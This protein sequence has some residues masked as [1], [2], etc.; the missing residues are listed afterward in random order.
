[1]APRSLY[2]CDG[3]V[4]DQYYQKG[5]SLPVFVGSGASQRGLGLGSVLGGLFRMAV[6]LLKQGGKALLKEGA[7]TGLQVAQDVMSGQTLKTAAQQRAKQAGKRLFEQAIG[8]TE[9]GI[10]R[11]RSSQQV[12]PLPPAPALAAAAAPTKQRQKTLRRRR[13]RQQQQQR[14]DIFS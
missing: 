8:Q 3:H 12:T 9:R 7:K 2:R 14:K 13:R 1:M 11:M 5:G 10:K 4:Y 6:P